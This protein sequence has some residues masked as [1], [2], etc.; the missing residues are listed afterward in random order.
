MTL[1]PHSPASGSRYSRPA[2]R[3]VTRIEPPNSFLGRDT[4][5]HADP[6]KPDWIYARDTTLAE[7]PAAPLAAPAAASTRLSRKWVATIMAS[8]VLH[9]A[10]A[11]WF[12][13]GGLDNDVLVEGGQELTTVQLGDGDI[14]A[15][16]SG[17]AADFE[18]TSVTI[19]PI[20]AP[21]AVEVSEAVPVETVEAVQPTIVETV[22]PVAEA[23][24]QPEMAAAAVETDA[25]QPAQ[26]TDIPQVLATDEPD[27]V[28]YVETVQPVEEVEA[29]KPGPAV[30][31]PRQPDVGAKREEAR[32]AAAEKQRK[33]EAE[34]RRAEQA[35]ARKQKAAAEKKKTDDARAKRA[36]EA[37]ERNAKK[38]KTAGQN[39]SSDANARKGRAD[40]SDK[41]APGS[42][43][44]KG[45]AS[46]AGNAAVSNYPGKVRGRIARAAGKIPRSLKSKAKGDVVVSFTV[47]AS[48][49]L[50]SVSIARSS[51]LAE[52][53]S[54]AIAAVR[55]AAPFP[56]IPDGRASWQFTVPISVR[57]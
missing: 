55:R 3:R 40:G 24:V 15:A 52:L 11:A 35:E 47:S 36:A 7:L 4:V 26:T 34:Q 50:G 20:T 54:A 42:S 43:T 51:G 17:A 53:D 28:E 19:I 8:I 25:A 10:V 30:E 48:G 23:A 56:K 44:G 32:R 6:V 22:E 45:K 13:A 49:G 27:V 29:T 14:D 18:A 9:V 12:L 1:Q 41:A 5:L 2:A 21:K 57:R 38:A 16:M 39:G 31:K 33:A 37:A 46:A